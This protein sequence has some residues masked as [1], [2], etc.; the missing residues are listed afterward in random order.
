MAKKD[1]YEILG[2]NKQ[3]SQGELKKA[4][5]KLAMKWHPDKNKGDMQ[6][7]EAFKE[8]TEAYDIL[9]NSEKRNKYDQYGHSAFSSMGGGPSPHGNPFDIFG[10]FFNSSQ[11]FRDGPTQTKRNSSLQ[12]SIEVD[13]ED[14]I[15]DSEKQIR[16]KKY[17]HCSPCKGTGTTIETEITICEQCRGQGVVFR[18]IGPMQVQQTCN[19]CGGSGQHIKNPCRSCNGDGITLKK[20]NVKIKIPKGANT[21]TKLK[22]QDGGHAIKGGGSGDLYATIIVRD[23]NKFQ[24]QYDDL[25]CEEE[26]N[27]IDMILGGKQIINTLHG[28]VEIKIPESTKSDSILNVKKQGLPNVRTHQHGDLYIT[29]KTKLPTNLTQEQKSILELY[30][31][32]I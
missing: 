27:F 24:R 29:L 13:L 30:Q 2:V 8:V 7:E 9:S 15:K 20:E 14:I 25:F 19:T 22:I 18:R 5:R 3:T 32:S 6:A 4:Y 28:K 16:Y 21:G 23:H 10:D 26:I 31:K 11:G 17:S 1:Y 12:V